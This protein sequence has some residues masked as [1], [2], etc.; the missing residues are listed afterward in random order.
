MANLNFSFSNNFLTTGEIFRDRVE[1]DIDKLG[2]GLNFNLGLDLAPL[3]FSYNNRDGG[4]GFSI[5]TG[6]SAFGNISL[7]G[8]MLTFKEVTDEKSDTNAAAFAEVGAGAFFTVQNF[9]IKIRPALY[10]PI[11]YVKRDDLSYTYRNYPGASETEFMLNYDLRVFTAFS[12]A[13]GDSFKLT[14]NPGFDFHLGV[15]YPLSE[16]L[17]L[18]EKNSLLDFIVGLDLINVPMIRGTMNNYMHVKGRIGSEDPIDILN[19]GLLDGNNF[20]MKEFVNIEDIVHGKEALKVTRPFKMLA[21]AEWQPFDTEMITFIPTLG[22]AVNPL[23]VNP[24]SFEGGVKSRLNLA[25]IF[26]ATLGIGYHDRLWVNSLDLALNLRAFQLDIGLSLQSADF[27][28]SWSGGG[29]GLGIGLKFG[30]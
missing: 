18:K 13:D 25:N 20:D 29:F 28:K 19:S 7:S 10:Y 26:L 16:V 12:L 17:G 27:A 11:A 6:L 4:W 21:W 23:Y 8:D 24:G 5:F 14:A 15:E 2:K 30:W 9:K 3:Y 22:F 1:V